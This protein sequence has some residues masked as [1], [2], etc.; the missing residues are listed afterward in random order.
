MPPS[1]A[2]QR[3]EEQRISQQM[4]LE[5]REGFGST[6]FPVHPLER[7]VLGEEHG[8][9]LQ[10]E[11][12]LDLGTALRAVGWDAAWPSATSCFPLTAPEAWKPPSLWLIHG[13]QSSRAL[14]VGQLPL[15]GY[16]KY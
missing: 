10:V 4:G 13:M 8:L 2:E 6:Q 5:S 3:D 11:G 7:E 1:L 14:R 15:T 16:I 9:E 12:A